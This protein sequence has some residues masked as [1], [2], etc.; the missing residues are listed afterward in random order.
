MP[1]RKPWITRAMADEMEELRKWKHQ[2]TDKARQEY[3]RLNNELRRTT[4]EA[5]EKWWNEKCKKLE[6]L[7]QKGSYDKVYEKVKRLSRKP[8]KCMI[9][10]SG[11]RGTKE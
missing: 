5:R 8:E 2:S 7:Q 6:D 11:G 9:T 3:K 4:E 1:S 10:K